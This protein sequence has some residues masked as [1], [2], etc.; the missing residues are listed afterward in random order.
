MPRYE[1][2]KGSNRR[3]WEIVVAGRTVHTRHGLVGSEGRTSAPKVFDT[4]EAA[5]S[6]ADKRIA[7]RRKKG[8]ELVDDDVAGQLC[9]PEFIE[10]ILANPDDPGPYLVYGDWL[11]GRGDPRGELVMVQHQLQ[12]RPDDAGLRKR[13]DRLT[14]QL[15]PARLAHMARK[16]KNPDR[17]ASGYCDLQW[18]LGFI[19]S[20]RIGRYSDRPPYTVRELVASLLAHPS[21]QVLQSLTIGAL[22][23][24]GLYDYT[25]V[26][27]EICRAE[28]AALRELFIADFDPEHLELAVSVLGD[29]SCLYPSLPGLE[30]LHLRG[31]SMDLGEHIALPALRELAIT[32]TVFDYRALESLAAASFPALER[33]ELSAGGTPLAGEGVARLIA[34]GNMKALTHLGLMEAQ[35]TGELVRRVLLGSDLLRQLQVL[36]LSGGSLSDRDAESMLSQRHA[37]AHLQRLDVTRNYLSERAA[38]AL[39]EV[40]PDVRVSNQRPP[41]VERISLSDQ[42]IFDFAPDSQSMTAARKLVKPATWPALGRDNNRL[43]GRCQGGELY[44]VYVDLEAMESG[45]T[46]PSMK[47]PCKHAIGLLMMAQSHTIPDEPPPAGLVERCEAGRPEWG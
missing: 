20:A 29:V 25:A 11:Q 6:D 17:A 2:G 31:G 10:A 3:F 27:E 9:N 28:P 15:A 8:F 34:A 33:L 5:R 19:V 16:K 24:P 44:D 38:A 23:P 40:C 14:R 12:A 13:E 1:S 36:D 45:C 42:E 30:R 32:T 4:E 7:D 18:R 21:A 39:S 41:A 26:V 35:E 22:G 43:W 37:L 46:C 47:Y